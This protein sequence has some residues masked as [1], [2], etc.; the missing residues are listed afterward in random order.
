MVTSRILSALIF[1][2]ISIVSNGQSQ[3]KFHSVNT[4][5][6]ATG[7]IG[8]FG[9]LQ[10]VNGGEYKKWFGGIGTGYDGYYYKS[11]PLFADVRRYLDDS[12]RF[13]L[14]G[15]VGYN[16]PGHNT[17]KENSFYSSF[18][19]TGGLYGDAGIGYKIKFLKHSSFLFSGGYSY[20]KLS[21]KVSVT[22]CPFVGPCYESIYNNNYSFGRLNFKAGII[23]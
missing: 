8:T 22:I 5:G 13:L 1:M 19:F 11:I 7:Q 10:T 14:Y 4:A 23:L 20:K 3:I 2:T 9:L 18:H 6:I 21:N 12:N 16:F 17:P 15:D